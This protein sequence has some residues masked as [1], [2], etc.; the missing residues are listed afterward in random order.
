MQGRV[1]DLGHARRRLRFMWCGISLAET[2]ATN[3][4]ARA[5]AKLGARWLLAS[6][7]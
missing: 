2:A 4:G 5:L 7:K 1:L 6:L 3:E